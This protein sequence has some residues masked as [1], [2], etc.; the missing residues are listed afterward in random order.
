MPLFQFRSRRRSIV[1][2]TAPDRRFRLF[3]GR[4]HLAAM[5]YPLPKDTSEIN[6][7]DFQHYLLRTGFRGNFAAPLA[8]PTSILDVGCGSGRWAMELAAY[9]PIAQVVGVDLVPP[10]TDDTQ[11]LGYGLEKR[12]ENYTFVAGNVLE[13]LPFPDQSFDFV[14]QR[15]LITAIPRDRWPFL[16]HELTRLARVG[17][18]VELA[19]CGVPE[20]GGPGLTSLWNSWI[21]L[22]SRRGV[23]FTMGHRIGELLQQGGLT[24]VQQ[25]R[26]YFPMGDYGGRIGRMSATDCLAVA[27]ALR[28]PVISQ[29][30]QPEDQYDQLMAVARD[31]F[32]RTNR[33]G[34]LPFYL[35]YGQRTA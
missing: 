20:D 23:D 22:C 29:G 33:G 24:G 16:V 18:W 2:E 9:F 17:G 7:L 13:G 28:A 32:G 4:R 10:A 11:T 19:E 1:T 12:P 5:P 6:R 25:Q 31:E 26:L 8:D 30:I 14:H 34:V 27:S 15:L 3:G 35:A 21:E